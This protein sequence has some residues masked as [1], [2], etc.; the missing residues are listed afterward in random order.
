MDYTKIYRTDVAALLGSGGSGSGGSGDEVLAIVP[1]R[2][3]PGAERV[4]RTPQ[5]IERRLEPLPRRL[6]RRAQ[7]VHGRARRSGGDRSPLDRILAI[8]WPWNRIDWDARLAGTS[9]AGGTGSHAVR[10]ADATRDGAGHF[11]VA[12]AHRFV[13][14]RRIGTDKFTF[15]AEAPRADVV[16]AR[17]RGRPFQRG[18]VVIGFVDGSQLT[19]DIGIFTAGQANRLVTALSPQ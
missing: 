19:V 4:E 16:Y 18:R 10:I 7:D 6:R 1:Y 14:V 11:A 9:V 15:A 17:R 8:D 5:V 3:A 12:T 2:L 13:V